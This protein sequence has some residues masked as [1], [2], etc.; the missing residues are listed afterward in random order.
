MAIQFLGYNNSPEGIQLH[1]GKVEAVQSW[2]FST[3][4]KEL[5]C[6]LGFANFYHRFIQNYS[7]ITAPITSLLKSNPKSLF[8]TPEATH[9]YQQLK[10]AQT[11]VQFGSSQIQTSKVEVDT[12]TS[13]VL[14]QHQ[15]KPPTLHPCAILHKLSQ[16]EQNYNIGNRELLAIKLVL[17]EWWHW[18]ERAHHTFLVLMNHPNLQYLREACRLNPRQEHWALFFTHFNFS[19]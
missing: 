6:F 11:S 2:P 18:L 8:W 14:P 3:T 13:A 19:M 9:A 15:G 5:Q 4:I 7:S 12:S 1:V 10:Q 16:V 17:E